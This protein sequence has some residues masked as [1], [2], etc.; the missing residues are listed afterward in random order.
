MTIHLFNDLEAVHRDILT[1][2]GQVEQMIHL[3]IDELAEPTKN[4]AETLQERDKAIDA[5]DVRIENECLKILAL[6]QPVAIDLRRITAVMKIT[7]ELERVADLGVHIAERASDAIG[8]PQETLPN[9]LRQMARVALDMLHRSIDSYVELDAEVARNVC[10]EDDL[11]D[12]MNRDIINDLMN[13]MQSRPE[14]VEPGM[15]LFSASRHIERIADHATNIAE[16]VVYLVSGEIIRHKTPHELA[17]SD[18][19]SDASPPPR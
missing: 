10:A 1:M 12:S 5:W 19:A 3:A 16:D 2:C 4:G 8:W 13:V 6:H 9:R 14:L 15:H 11:V 17:N 7:G 18:A